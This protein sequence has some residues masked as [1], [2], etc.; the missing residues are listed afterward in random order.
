M[1]DYL[2]TVLKD[3]SVRADEMDGVTGVGGMMTG[4]GGAGVGGVAVKD[5]EFGKKAKVALF[6]AW[7]V[8]DEIMRRRGEGGVSASAAGGPGA[9]YASA[10][11]AGVSAPAAAPA[12]V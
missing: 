3:R 8:Q 4:G 12:A 5:E 11:S 1:T 7:K 9:G 2:V 6:V 10:A